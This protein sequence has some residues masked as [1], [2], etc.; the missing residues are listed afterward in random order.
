MF[1]LLFESWPAFSKD[2]SMK[3]Q[4]WFRIVNKHIFLRHILKITSC[5]FADQQSCVNLQ[6]VFK[7]SMKVDSIKWRWS[8]AQN[9]SKQGK[10]LKCK[11]KFLNL[12]VNVQ[13]NERRK[14]LNAEVRLFTFCSNEWMGYSIYKGCIFCQPSCLVDSNEETRVLEAIL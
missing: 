14:K 5:K 3:L 13:T 4:I 2:F 12:R 9:N 8:K 7:D 1:N 10:I 11:K 6:F